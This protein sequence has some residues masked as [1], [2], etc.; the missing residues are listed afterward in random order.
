[1]KIVSNKTASDSHL[2]LTKIASAY[3]TQVQF[4]LT[5]I[6]LPPSWIENEAERENQYVRG[7]LAFLFAH[8]SAKSRPIFGR[9]LRNFD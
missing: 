8:F 6:M 2:P 7:I 3:F 9:Y 4:L 5:F 1:M